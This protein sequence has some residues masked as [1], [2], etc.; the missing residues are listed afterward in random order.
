VSETL[1]KAPHLITVTGKDVPGITSQLMKLLDTH[2]SELLDIGQSII[3][4]VLSLTLLAQ[5]PGGR[6]GLFETDL[7]ETCRNLG[8]EFEFRPMTEE[9]RLTHP[10]FSPRPF[11]Y[12]VTLIAYPI[13][14]NALHQV[15]NLLAGAGVNIEE[16]QRLSEGEPLTCVEMKVSSPLRLERTRLKSDLLC[17]SAFLKIDIALQLDT[18]HRRAKRLVVFDLDSTLIQSEGIDELARERGCFQ[19]VAEITHQAMA[20][21][22]DYDESLRQ[23]VKKLKGLTEAQ[24]QAVASRL[25]LTPGADELVRSLKGLGYQ[26]AVI[27]G[28]FTCIAERI[29]TQLGIDYAFANELEIRNGA[30]TGKVLPPIVNG[31]RKA[32]LLDQLATR[33][34]IP[35]S[36]VIAVGDGANDQEMLDRAGLGVAF[37]AKPVLRKSADF[38][39]DRGGLSSILYLLG[40]SAQDRRTL[41][42]PETRI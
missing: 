28:G 14:A 39:L 5:I 19:E 32:E 12:V 16:I 7:G 2:Q 20:G 9:E 10:R 34:G 21:K 41:L 17:L 42:E 11:C 37:R 38:A 30:V 6:L 33:L 4:P 23:R 1:V 36:Q 25:E 22:F 13:T 18:L 35:L 29:R 40:L 3:P 15:S 26:T 27:S 24:V 8:L 31:H